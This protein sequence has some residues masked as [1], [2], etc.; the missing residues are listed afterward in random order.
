MAWISSPSPS[1]K[2]HIFLRKIKW[3]S[4]VITIHEDG[5][6]ESRVVT[7]CELAEKQ[8]SDLIAAG[9]SRGELFFVKIWKAF[10]DVSMLF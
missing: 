7:A 10:A 2:P 6:Y 8:V 9:L 3:G 5:A 1:I 4:R